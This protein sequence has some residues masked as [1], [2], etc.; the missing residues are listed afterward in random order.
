MKLFKP[1]SAAA[2]AASADAD[3]ARPRREPEARRSSPYVDAR[4]EW[5]ERYGNYIKRER[6]WRLFAYV[7][8]LVAV[9]ETFAL[10]TLMTQQKVVSYVVEVDRLGQAAAVR[11]ADAATIVDQRVVKSLLSR[12]VADTRQVVTDGVAQKQAIDRVFSMIAPNTRARGF[13]A[14]FYRAN[15]PYTRA[16]REIVSVEIISVLPISGE[17]YQIEWEE[18]TRNVSG[19]ITGRA[20]WK[21]AATVATNPP[22]DEP[23]I[24]SN[25]IGLYIVDLNWTQ[26]L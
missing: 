11:Q 24:R 21:A 15:L 8:L 16:E 5:N 25:P 3:E 1:R 13:V 17:T 19:E 18:T 22:K 12:F 26:T 7:L 9:C 6:N 20:R 14:E 4:R 2:G 10:W 23:S